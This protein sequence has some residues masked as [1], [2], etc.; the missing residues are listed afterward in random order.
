[1]VPPGTTAERPVLLAAILAV[2]RYIWSADDDGEEQSRSSSFL[3]AQLFPERQKEKSEK[4]DKS[5]EDRYN[6]STNAVAFG[7]ST[8]ISFVI[9]R[10]KM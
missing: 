6:D 2:C 1:M 3:A 9:S 5:G 7:Q 10:V 8:E 4:N